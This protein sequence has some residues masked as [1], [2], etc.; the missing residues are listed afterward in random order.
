MKNHHFRLWLA[1]FMIG[2]VGASLLQST[3][4][5]F[6][7]DDTQSDTF[8]DINEARTVAT[9]KLRT[10]QPTDITIKEEVSLPLMYVFFLAPQGYIVVPDSTF[11]PPVIA[12]SF[13]NDFGEINED[14][15]LLSLLQADLS[16]RVTYHT[17]IPEDILA[18]RQDQ[19]DAMLMQTPLPEQRLGATTIGPLLD[20]T[21]HQN[22][23]YN[24]FC[25]IDLASGERSVAG[26]P[27]VAMA[28][29]LNYHQTTQQVQ[30]NDSDDYRHAYGG[31]N[32]WID[33]DAET[34]DFPTFPELNAY[35][36][37]LESHY[38]NDVAITDD[39]K[40][41]LT[42]A[43][44]VA[45]T[46]V[47]HPSG[48]GTFGV[49]QA[50]QAYQRFA[51]D[52]VSLLDDDDT[53]VYE[54]VQANIEDGL[55]VHIAVVTEGWTA[56]HNMVV[57]G[58]NTD[59]SFHINFGWG[60]T[61]D[62]WYML[63]E[64]LPYELTVLEGVIVDIIPHHQGTGLEGHGVLAWAEVTPGSE[65][66]GSFTI[67]NTDEPGST[68]DWEIATWPDWGTWTFTP[69]SGENLTPEEGERTIT[70]TVMAPETKKESF[71]GSVKIV[72]IDDSSDSCL[73]HVSLV[74]PK[75]QSIEPF[76]LRFLETHPRL[77][78][79]LQYIF[80]F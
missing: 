62:G 77:L 27:A 4:G 40:A 60:G 10:D 16:S 26:C 44:G 52:D 57:D 73:I 17:Y 28:Q 74:T 67:S 21:W 42:F 35:L 13:T 30:F 14:N 11:L 37:T 69:S 70:V 76:I 8:I 61:Y 51:F 29:I 49:N 50:Y 32:Y 25:P 72:N 39:D 59:G 63:P 7:P 38:Q 48:S 34:Y 43:C 80:G 5:T 20:T 75:H 33:N 71:A 6:L 53:N 19:W 9:T 36:T 79:L 64:E 41:A 47:Y 65:L 58:Y 18:T 23:P 54:R 31:N 46:Q 1:I 66:T 3:T 15:I 78:S 45:A 56:G 12:Y 24:N 55:P 68:I 22:A 2:L